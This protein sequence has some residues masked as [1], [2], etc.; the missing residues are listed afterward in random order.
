[1]H[2]PVVP[3]SAQDMQVP[4]QAALQQTPCAQK[5]VVHW[6]ALSHPAPFGRRQSPLLQVNPEGQCAATVQGNTTCR[7]G[8]DTITCSRNPLLS[9]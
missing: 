1:V 9:T 5:P 6:D 2:V 7:A 8:S 3:V 4:V